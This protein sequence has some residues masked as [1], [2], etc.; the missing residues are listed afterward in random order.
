MTYKKLWQSV[1]PEH[2]K[3]KYQQEI[4]DLKFEAIQTIDEAIQGYEAQP[5]ANAIMTVRANDDATYSFKVV[6][7]KYKKGS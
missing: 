1:F 5:L 2:Y 7:V 3:E 6:K 4:N